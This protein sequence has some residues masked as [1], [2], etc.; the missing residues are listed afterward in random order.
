MKSKY[1]DPQFYI[2]TKEMPFN[3]RIKTD[4][5]EPIVP[6]VLERALE[7]TMQRY[8]YFKLRVLRDG[9]EYVTVPNDLP[10]VCYEGPEVLDLG[11]PEV[12]YH[13]LAVS[14][15]DCEVSVFVSHVV[16]D[17]AGIYPLVKTLLYYYICEAFDAPLNARGIN[18]ADDPLFEDEADE[19]CNPEIFEHA[20]DFFEPDRGD[21]FRLKN[22]GL[23]NDF[24]PTVH[25]VK[26]SQKD[27]MR[28]NSISDGSPCTLG[29]VLAAEAIWSLHPELEQNLVCDVSLNCR[30]A[31]GTKHNYRQ[32]CKS[33]PLIYRPG[34]KE[35]TTRE[36]CTVSRGMTMLNS[37]PE[38]AWKFFGDTKK[39]YESVDD[40]SFE[41]KKKLIG[42]IALDTATNNT[43]SISYV[44]QV[45]LGSI[46]PFIDSMYNITD[47]STYET[48]FIEINAENAWF[49][50]A[51]I[52]GF[53]NDDYYKAF[54]KTL[55]RNRIKYREE[56]SGPM[57]IPN[58]WLPE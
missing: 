48:L 54:L 41:E 30:G 19:P 47:G 8:P 10:V 1:Y 38:N 58:T 25:Y 36:L 9:E 57:G 46:E 26:V 17:G 35:K 27:F 40:L 51:F 28:Y 15:F 53:S 3:I 56:G 24:T 21:F 2:S 18:L 39:L 5:V 31:L 43:F 42:D 23:V 55:E 16:A 14:Y 34:I 37:Q 6:D 33:F 32:L 20:E 49:D 22:G 12:N 52:Q 45:G 29:A 11:S 50:I 13:M 7:K 4:L 44:G